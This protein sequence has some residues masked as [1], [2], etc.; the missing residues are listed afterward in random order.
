MQ[1][2]ESMD[3]LVRVTRTLLHEI[4]RESFQAAPIVELANNDPET[5]RTWISENILLVPYAGVLRGRSGTMM[6]RSGNSLDRAILLAT[7][8][9]HAG[10]KPLL[11]RTTL[12]EEQVRQHLLPQVLNQDL[13]HLREEVSPLDP[14]VVPEGLTGESYARVVEQLVAH[15]QRLESVLMRTEQ[16]LPLLAG[17]L[18]RLGGGSAEET[19]WVELLRDHWWVRIGGESGMVLDPALQV[20]EGIHDQSEFSGTVA[21][22]PD[23]LYHKVTAR[24]VIEQWDEGKLNEKIPLEQTWRAADIAT[25]VIVFSVSPTQWDTKLDVLNEEREVLDVQIKKELAAKKSWVPSVSVGGKE[26]TQK[27][28]MPTVNLKIRMSRRKPRRWGVRSV[29]WGLWAARP[30]RKGNL[31]RFGR[32]GYWS[33]LMGSKEYSAGCWW[34]GLA[35]RIAG[36]TAFPNP[37]PTLGKKP[38]WIDLLR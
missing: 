22:L 23:E 27:V 13:A 11:Q 15:E 16:Q 32:N 26:I 18:D 20:V 7:L 12:S 17:Q 9:E 4:P 6:D 37:V 33:D 25:E 1:L 19:K 38:C 35:R 10:H 21:D 3:D 2:L 36:T 30:N 34:I 5:L 14:A 24:V 31:P 8:L 29:Y 28:S